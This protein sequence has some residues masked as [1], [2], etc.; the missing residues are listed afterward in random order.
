MGLPVLVGFELMGFAASSLKGEAA[1]Q[2]KQ[3]A[4]VN[5]QHQAVLVVVARGIPAA[6]VCGCG[7]VVGSV[8]SSSS[9]FFNLIYS[10]NSGDIRGIVSSPR[11]NFT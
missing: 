4:T 1:T 7:R 11:P 3:P 6:N 8:N 10:L 5:N 2:M 9:N